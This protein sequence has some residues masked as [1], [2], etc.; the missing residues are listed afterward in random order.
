LKPFARGYRH[1]VAEEGFDSHLSFH[2][3]TPAKLAFV[4]KLLKAFPDQV[5]KVKGLVSKE[6]WKTSGLEAAI[7]REKGWGFARGF[8]LWMKER[9][10]AWTV[11][12]AKLGILIE[13]DDE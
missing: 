8:I 9:F 10:S 1:L 11:A 2:T 7:K 3:H 12:K 4:A 5:D 13:E 6:A